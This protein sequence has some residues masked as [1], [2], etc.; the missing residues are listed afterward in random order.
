MEKR[1]CNNVT[2]Y[3]H[4]WFRGHRIRHQIN[5]LYIWAFKIVQEWIIIYYLISVYLIFFFI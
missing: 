2:M 3:I 4:V 5:Q 1:R